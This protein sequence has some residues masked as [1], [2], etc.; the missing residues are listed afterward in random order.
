M[1]FIPFARYIPFTKHYEGGD[2]FCGCRWSPMPL[3]NSFEGDGFRWVEWPHY[4]A[5]VLVIDDDNFSFF[6]TKQM[7]DMIH[8]FHLKF[9][10]GK[11]EEERDQAG[12]EYL[13]WYKAFCSAMHKADAKNA[14]LRD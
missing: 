12:D 2:C 11:T 14:E 5:E 3:A 1:E 13:K 6:N 9:L 10:N 4:V 7:D 8:D